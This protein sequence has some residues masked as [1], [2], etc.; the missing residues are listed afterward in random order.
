MNDVNNL[1]KLLDNWLY[2]IIDYLPRIVLALLI[3]FIFYFLAKNFKKYSLK[4][5]TKVFAKQRDIARI[6]SILVVE[7]LNK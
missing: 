6:I 1:N 5:Y 4:F 2:I 3:L 7:E